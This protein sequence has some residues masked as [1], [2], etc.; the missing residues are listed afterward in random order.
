MHFPSDLTLAHILAEPQMAEELERLRKPAE[1]R[2]EKV[3]QLGT[4]AR[5][6]RQ[7]FGD[8]G[9]LKRAVARLGPDMIEDSAGDDFE[10][11]GRVDGAIL[12]GLPD[13][14][15]DFLHEVRNVVRVHTM[16]RGDQSDDA[17]EVLPDEPIL[18]EQRP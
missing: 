16:A 1:P 8:A 15:P 11:P 3:R 5:R 2:P 13:R 7:V 14:E 9:E 12:A 10:D 6:L 4:V 18:S 17:I